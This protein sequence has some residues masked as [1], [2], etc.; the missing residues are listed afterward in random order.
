MKT[1]VRIIRV[2]DDIRK[3]IKYQLHAFE[4]YFNK[5]K[6]YIGAHFAA[7]A[8]DSHCNL[9]AVGNQD[10]IE[11]G[12]PASDYDYSSTKSGWPNSTG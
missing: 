9:A 7:G 11:H 10:F 2:P 6:E 5:R 3:Q 12:K 1:Y 4:S 8:D